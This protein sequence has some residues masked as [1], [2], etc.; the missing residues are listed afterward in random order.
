MS[1]IGEGFYGCQ[2]IFLLIP[3]AIEEGTPADDAWSGPAIMQDVDML[4]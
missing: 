2:E 4:Y 1:E 3:E